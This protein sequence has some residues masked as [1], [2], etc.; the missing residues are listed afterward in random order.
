LVS[1]TPKSFGNPILSLPQPSIAEFKAGALCDRE[2]EGKTQDQ[3]RG[4]EGSRE[5]EKGREAKREGELAL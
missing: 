4:E 2:G 5:K 1:N 3:E